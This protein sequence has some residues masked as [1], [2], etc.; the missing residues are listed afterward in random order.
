MIDI[1]PAMDIIDGKCVRLSQG[2]FSLKTEYRESPVETARRFRDAGLTRLHMVDLDGARDGEPKN[3]HTLEAVAK[4]SGMI[5]DFGGG[6]RTDA[7]VENALSAGAAMINVTSV[8]VHE[9]ERFESWVERYG[10]QKFLL[11]ADSHNGRVAAHGWKTR[12][13]WRVADFVRRYARIGILDV[14]VTDIGR[15]GM[16]SGPNTELYKQVLAETGG[17]RLIASGGV[18]SVA[19]IEAVKDVG[20]RGVI[21]GKALYEGRITLEEIAG[22]A[23]KKDHSLSGR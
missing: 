4:D 20:C 21:V 3:L 11:G 2:D 5:V 6:V 7:D 13:E 22:Y 23:G 12:S 15:D 14:F 16:L 17:I 1:I 19:D 8:A 9:P 18:R 10:P